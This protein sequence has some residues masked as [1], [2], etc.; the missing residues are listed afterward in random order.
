MSNID[1]Q[2]SSK[3]A[4][5]YGFK[6]ANTQIK[7]QN[8]WAV[9]KS[10]LDD[11]QLQLQISSDRIINS[12]AIAQQRAMNDSL[13]SEVILNIRSYTN[14][15]GVR[16]VRASDEKIFHTKEKT[17]FVFN[18]KSKNTLEFDVH[19]HK[20]IIPGYLE[21][22][23]SVIEVLSD[24]K[25]DNKYWYGKIDEVQVI[26]IF[27]KLANHD[28]TTFELSG[29]APSAYSSKYSIFISMK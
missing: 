2:Y 12:C 25:N 8:T 13:L 24:D 18:R 11:L 21:I 17:I 1:D 3:S 29:K 27:T 14:F 26:Q 10:I 23:S 9:H 15:I 20:D 6:D 16:M 5:L 28:M 19:I 4:T 22:F 7:I